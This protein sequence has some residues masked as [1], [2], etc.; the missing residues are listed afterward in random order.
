MCENGLSRFSCA[1]FD[2]R[3]AAEVEKVR[4]EIGD[5]NGRRV[6]ILG[7]GGVDIGRES[8]MAAIREMLS[9]MDVE[10]VSFVGIDPPEKLAE[11]GSADFNIMIHPECARRTADWYSENLGIPYVEPSMGAPVGYDSIRRFL[12]EVSDVTDMEDDRAREVLDKEME[13]I[14]RGTEDILRTIDWRPMGFEGLPSDI[15]PIME[16]MHSLFSVDTDYVIPLGTSDPR[17]MEGVEAFLRGIGCPDAVGGD[18]HSALAIVFSDRTETDVFWGCFQGPS[19]V[20]I[21][22]LPS[23]RRASEGSSLMWLEGCRY[24]IST[25]SKVIRPYC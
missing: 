22:T 11:S 6:N 2:E 14:L 7:Y 3:V 4:P 13:D 23:D 17:D 16:W 24:L 25:I 9:L 18:E 8:G 5:S 12:K 19:R 21:E 10:V 20:C 1:P 15:L